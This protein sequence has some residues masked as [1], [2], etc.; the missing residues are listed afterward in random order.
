MIIEL[1]SQQTKNGAADF[2]INSM[3]EPTD[4]ILPTL[5]DGK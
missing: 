2:V 1:V 4:I 3:F 5:M